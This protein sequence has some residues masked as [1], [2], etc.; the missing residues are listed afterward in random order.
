MSKVIQTIMASKLSTRNK[1]VYNINHI[2]HLVKT[3]NSPK[4]KSSEFHECKESAY[5]VMKSFSE[6]PLDLLDNHLRSV[7]R[8]LK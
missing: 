3:S 5:N 2:E 6:M 7:W 1:W 4:I 8:Q